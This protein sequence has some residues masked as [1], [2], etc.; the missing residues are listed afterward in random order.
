MSKA[1]YRTRNKSA[2]ARGFRKLQKDAENTCGVFM[3]NVARDML[4]QLL[5]FHDEHERLH[6]V[7]EKNTLAYALAHNGTI[8]ENG[9][10]HGGEDDLPGQAM[11]IAQSIVSG[12]KG[13]VAVV[14]SE[15]QGWYNYADEEDMLHS[16]ASEIQKKSLSSLFGAS[17]YLTVGA[18]PKPQ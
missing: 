13:W 14:V 3:R 5:R 1:N 18:I 8:I 12:A 2:I 6:H 16:T 15:M 4:M 7:D 17:E 11:E 9:Y 10:H